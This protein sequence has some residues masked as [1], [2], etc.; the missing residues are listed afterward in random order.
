MKYKTKRRIQGSISV[1]L[2]IILLPMMVLSAVI[3]DTSR[4]NMARSMVSSAGDLA[5]NSALADYD[6]ILKDVYGLFAMSQNKEPDKLAEDIKK[7]FEDTLV[8]YGVVNPAEAGQYVDFL[9][10]DFKEVLAGNNPDGASNFL[11]MELGDD[12]TVTKEEQSSLANPDI[13]RK[14]VVDYMKY[15]AP[16]NFGMSFLDSVKAFMTVDE[17]NDVVEAQVVAQ[18]SLQGVAKACNELIGKIRDHDRLVISIDS[19]DGTEMVKGLEGSTD[20][21]EVYI[22]TYHEQVNKYKDS[23]AENYQRINE[24][25][26]VFHLK[27][28]SV[29]DKYLSGMSLPAGEIF[30]NGD[31]TLKTTNCGLSAPAA[32]SGDFDTVLNMVNQL[33]GELDN[34][35]PYTTMKSS[36]GDDTFLRDS[37]LNGDLTAFTNYGDAVNDFIAFEQVLLDKEGSPIKYSDIKTTLEGL[38]RYEVYNKK[39]LE[40]YD[41]KIT[42]KEGEVNVKQGQVDAKQIEVN[43]ANN[44]VQAGKDA[45]ELANTKKGE[46]EDAE[47]TYNQAVLDLAAASAQYQQ[48]VAANPVEADESALNAAIQAKAEAEADMDA[49]KTDWQKAEANRPSD[50]EMAQR[51]ANAQARQGELNTLKGQLTQLKQELELLKSERLLA[52]QTYKAT[53]MNFQTFVYRYQRDLKLYKDFMETAKNLIEKDAKPIK[54]Q[55]TKI[56]DNVQSVKNALGLID[57]DIVDLYTYLDDYNKKVEDWHGITETYESNNKAD[58]FSKQNMADIEAAR[59]EFNTDSIAT[60]SDWTH[61]IEGEYNDFLTYLKA[62]DTFKYGTMKINSLETIAAIKA[63]I[64]SSVTSSL[65]DIVTKDEA[66]AGFASLYVGGT[67][68]SIEIDDKTYVL[69][70]PDVEGD[71][72]IPVQFLRYLNSTYPEQKVVLENLPTTNVE[73]NATKD[74]EEQYENMKSEVSSDEEG[75]D[76]IDDVDINEYGYTFKSRPVINWGLPSAGYEK[77]E[78][79]TTSMSIGTDDNGDLKTSEAMDNQQ[80]SLDGVLANVG[81]VLEASLENIYIVNYIFENF[82]YNTIVQEMAVKTEN[83]TTYPQVIA[84][85]TNK[86]LLAKYRGTARTLS[87]YSITGANNYLYGAEVEYMLF[88]NTDP[89]KNVTFVKGSIYAMRFAFNCIFAFTD[90]EIRNTTMAAGLAVQAATCGIVPYKVVQIVLQLALAAAESAIDLDMMGKGLKVVVVKTKETWNMSI[91]GAVDLVTEAVENTAV[92]LIEDAVSKVSEGINTMLEKTGAEL[93]DAINELSITVGSAAKGKGEEIIDGLY[94][95]VQSQLD[96]ILNELKY[97]EFKNIT[98]PQVAIDMVEAKFETLNSNISGIISQYISGTIVESMNVG[99]A[100]T[101]KI[102]GVVN[103]IKDSVVSKISAAPK[104]PDIGQILSDEMTQI[105]YDL[106]KKMQSAIDDTLNDVTQATNQKISSLTTKLSNYT[107]D[108]LENLSEEEIKKVKDEISGSLN[109]FSNTYLKD[110]SADADIEVGTN[111][112]GEHGSQSMGSKM[113]SMI[114]FGYKDYLMLM[115]FI[116]VCVNDEPVLCRMADVIELNLSKAEG[117]PTEEEKNVQGAEFFKHKKTGDFKMKNAVT[118][119]SIETSVDLDMLLMDMEFFNKMLGDTTEVEDGLKAASGIHY[120]GLA[121]Y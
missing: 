58:S 12:F 106:I 97:E 110:N 27:P 68:P 121:G 13:L 111:R 102:C 90:S 115:M 22:A 83:Y 31:G 72:I 23:W 20:G 40:L 52:E 32:P 33:K 79:D 80:D 1:L 87:N 113:A 25:L 61:A 95:E 50:Q 38:Y 117:T 6:T 101:N 109:D 8:N 62:D 7:Y 14:Q 64:P 37:L 74:P 57:D 35:H 119:V 41:G 42:A 82:S 34:N 120:K 112:P 100:L 81:K 77:G 54:A 114:K 78:A 103:E 116:S 53:I 47:K 66:T 9:M 29:D 65:P 30:V 55:I 51:E 4:I 93:A 45:I 84:M 99:D 2:I 73:G 108:Q 60:L 92:A 75:Q 85:S 94:V 46:Y 71:S 28:V 56:N 59:K 39:L 76:A 91:S 17:Q 5:L 89:K 70:N 86:D 96:I 63:A 19:K 118:Y 21:K 18:E 10:G 98:D 69:P 48:D 105:K 3:V 24:L 107:K 49:A 15:R 11:K 16:L 104:V 36:Y 67:A 26:F 43:N 88:G 44:A